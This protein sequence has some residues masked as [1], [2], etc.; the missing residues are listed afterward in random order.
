MATKPAD[1]PSFH[2]LVIKEHARKELID[3]RGRKGLVIDPSLSGPLS[4]IAEF[5]L[6]KEHGI[7]KIYHLGPDK[8]ETDCK[9][10]V[11]ITRPTISLCKHI[12]AHVR[13]QATLPTS[14]PEFTVFFVPRKTIVCEQVL[15]E[16]GVLGDINLGEYHLD[17]IPL[18]EDVLSLELDGAFRD[19]FLEGDTSP[20]YYLAKALLKVQSVAGIVSKIMGAG[21]NAK[22]LSDLL[23]R[24]RTEVQ[25]STSPDAQ[26][27]FPARADIDSIVIIDRQVDF[28]TPLCTQLTYEGLV[29]EV[30]GVRS[31]FVEVDP[32]YI[33]ASGAPAGGLGNRPKR[34]PLSG[35]DKLF[36]QLR[37][38]NFAVVG[39]ALNQVARRLQGDIEGRHQAKTV[40]QIKEFIGKL[41][42]L[43]SERVSLKLHTSLAEQITKFTQDLDFN[44]MLEVQQNVVAGTSLNS[45]LDYIEELICRQ[46]PLAHVLRLMG[47]Y[48]QTSGGI[49]PKNYDFLRREVCQTYGFEHIITFQNFAKLGIIKPSDTSRNNFSQIRKLAR[50]IVDDVDEHKPNDISYVYSGYAPLSIRLV[51]LATT[52]FSVNSSMAALASAGSKAVNSLSIKTPTAAVES[53]SVSW[54]GSEEV[55]REVNTGVFFEEEQANE[56][57]SLLSVLSKK[58]Q[59]ATTLVVFIGGCTFTEIAALRFLSKQ[60]SRDYVTLTTNI[61]NGGSIVQSLQEKIVEKPIGK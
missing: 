22:I 33:S 6:L 2:S 17:I 41:T 39:G 29:D 38:L 3:V 50:L 43:E 26:K 1:S 25:S 21:K 36:S 12:A 5:S 7:E 54:K 59:S 44:K 4:L 35:A 55:L 37:N 28:I 16:E 20:I 30:F 14:K 46:A 18:D 24:M 47:L 34:V 9:S 53:Q 13:H 51:Q 31:T 42:G 10:L 40:S 23:I 11:Y 57:P 52:K 8:P 45:H 58:T 19:V 56:D 48:S 60:E 32:S 27:I 61:I 49:K 15:E